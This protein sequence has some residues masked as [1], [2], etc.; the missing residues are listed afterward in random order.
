MDHREAL[1]T[2]RHF[3]ATQILGQEKLVERLLIALLAGI[4]ALALAAM[5]LSLSSAMICAALGFSRGSSVVMGALG[6]SFMVV[7]PSPK[8]PAIA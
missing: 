3:L 5:M 1:V 6:S 8:E 2:L 4:A 7:V